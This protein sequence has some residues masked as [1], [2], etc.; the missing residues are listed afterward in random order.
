MPWEDQRRV[1]QRL[2]T[3]YCWWKNPAPVQYGDYRGLSHCHHRDKYR[4]TGCA[5]FLPSTVVKFLSNSGW[6]VE[7]ARHGHPEETCPTWGNKPTSP[8]CSKSCAVWIYVMPCDWPLGTP[9]VANT[10]MF[11]RVSARIDTVD[12]QM[13]GDTTTTKQF[14]QVMSYVSMYNPQKVG[15]LGFP[16]LLK[17]PP[18]GSGG[19]HQ[20]YRWMNLGH[21][22]AQALLPQCHET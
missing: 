21:P 10:R 17:P 1:H 5:G 18:C 2:I 14:H 7:L 12:G 19:L 20:M 6:T 11:W 8:E 15:P 3:K 4:T 13:G 22:T 16:T 9:W